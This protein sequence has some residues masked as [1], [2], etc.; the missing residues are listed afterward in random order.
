MPQKQ[1]IVYKCELPC[2]G[3][4][5]GITGQRLEQRI[6]QHI[7]LAKKGPRK[8]LHRALY[9]SNFQANWSILAKI[10]NWDLACELERDFIKSLN[11][12]IAGIGFNLTDG[13]EGTPGA[14]WSEE[15]RSAASI[16]RKG[17]ILSEE[18]KKKLSE[19]KKNGYHPLRGQKMPAEWAEKIRLAGIGRKNTDETKDKMSGSA[20]K[21]Y[22]KNPI[23]TFEVFDN[24]M[25]SMGIWNNV[26][27]CSEDLKISKSRIQQCLCG[28]E[29]KAGGYFIKRLSEKNENRKCSEELKKLRKKSSIE[30]WDKRAKYIFDV[31]DKDN[32]YVGRWNSQRRCAIELNLRPNKVSG[33]FNNPKRN[34]S[35]KGYTFKK[36]EHATSST[37]TPTI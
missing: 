8:S 29:E 23:N 16:R 20:L 22:E 11:S 26:R 31:F 5:I 19:T 35:C 28:S 30:S 36:V 24:N 27:K 21:R 37:T 15:S 13:G 2:G 25:I 6:Y 10:N 18:T 33:C 34:K 1:F 7:H 17:I 3:I 14:I 32:N 4:Y 9:L 12:N